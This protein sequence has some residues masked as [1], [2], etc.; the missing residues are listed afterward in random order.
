MNINVRAAANHLYRILKVYVSVA[1]IGAL[2][3]IAFGL[4]DAK[5]WIGAILF[6]LLETLVVVFYLLRKTGLVFE[7]GSVRIQFGDINRAAEN[8]IENR[9]RLSSSSSSN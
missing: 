7:I 6:I 4:I 2:T 9:S 5:P 1:L 3:A 8:L